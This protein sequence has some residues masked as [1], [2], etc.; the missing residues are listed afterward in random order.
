MIANAEMVDM[1][2]TGLLT[3]YNNSDGPME[4]QQ[5][6]YVR[7]HPRI[8]MAYSVPSV[9]AIHD[10]FGH[11]TGSWTLESSGQST[12]WLRDLLPTYFAKSQI[13]TWGYE[14]GRPK[15]NDVMSEV[16]YIK[17]AMKLLND[18]TVAR[19][20]EPALLIATQDRA[21]LPIFNHTRAMVANQSANSL[22]IFN[23]ITLGYKNK[24]SDL[25]KI[26]TIEG[27]FKEALDTIQQ[28]IREKGYLDC[29]G[30]LSK[31]Y[32][33]DSIPITEGQSSEQITK[34]PDLMSWMRGSRSSTIV[35]CG[36]HGSGKT[37]STRSIYQYLRQSGSSEYVATYFAFDA[38]DR[39]RN[40]ENS[41]LISV[42]Q[43][44][45]FSR[46][47]LFRKIKKRYKYTFENPGLKQDMWILFRALLRSMRPLTLFCIINAVD[48][49]L[50][51]I[52]G[53]LRNL[54]DL[55]EEFTTNLKILFTFTQEAEIPGVIRRNLVINLESFNKEHR[56]LED[57]VSHR[58]SVI[59]SNRPIL[60]E[61]QAEI[62]QKLAG[63]EDFLQIALLTEQLE[64][65]N[66]SSTPDLVRRQIISLDPDLHVLVEKC[67]KD[68]EEWVQLALSW[69]ML[70]ARPL[71][72]R[73]L[74]VAVA[75]CQD[76]RF[77]EANAGSLRAQPQPLITID[78]HVA[79]NIFD[80]L[81][82]VLGPLVVLKGGYIKF[83]NRQV[84]E[85]FASRVFLQLNDWDITR[86]CIMYISTDE[87]ENI[88]KDDGSGLITS[89][90]PERRLAFIDYATNHWPFHYQRTTF[91]AS[92]FRSVFKTL[93][94]MNWMDTWSN[95]LTQRGSP[96]TRQDLRRMN[97]LH[98][99]SELGFPG[100]IKLLLQ[101]QQ[102][103]ADVAIALD[104]ASRREHSEIV[105]QLL[106]YGIQDAE[107]I[108]KALEGPCGQGFAS[109]VD[110]LLGELKSRNFDLSKYP[111][112]LLALAARNGHLS[113]VQSLIDT[114]VS[115]DSTWEG[116]CPLHYA[117]EQGH[118]DIVNVL[119]KNRANPNLVDP[120]KCAPLHLA[121]NNQDLDI[122]Q[123]LIVAKSSVDIEDEDGRR[124]LHISVE[125]GH[126]EAVKLLLTHNVDLEC[127]TNSG[128]TPLHLAAK[129]GHLNI[130][131]LLLKHKVQ[132]DLENEEGC[133]PLLLAAMGGHNKILELLLD[134]GVRLNHLD[135]IGCSALLSSSRHGHNQTA[136][137][138]LENG[139]DPNA[140]DNPDS[141]P[142]IEAV[143]QGETALVRLMIKR[144]AKVDVKPDDDVYFPIHYSVIYS[145]PD[146]VR[147]FI[148]EGCDINS[149]DSDK[150]Q[151]PL[152][153]AMYA[154]HLEIVNILLEAKADVTIKSNTDETVLHFAAYGDHADIASLLLESG[155]DIDAVDYAENT[156]LHHA[157]YRHSENAITFLMRQGANH[158]I[159][160][161][162]FYTPFTYAV[163]LEH[164][165]TVRQLLTLGV[166]PK[167]FDSRGLTSLHIAAQDS[168]IEI[169]KVL[170]KELNVDVN[171]VSSTGETPLH[172]A[173][174]LEGLRWF[175]ENGANANAGSNK[176][177]T[178]L[179]V[180]AQREDKAAV[181][182][183]LEH[184]AQIHAVTKGG[185]TALHY[186]LRVGN[187][188]TITLLL[189][190]GLNPN[191]EA[192]NGVTPL[193]EAINT[194]EAAI[195]KILLDRGAE[196]NHV[197]GYGNTALHYAASMN[198][199]EV[200]TILF[201]RGA[202]IDLKDNDGDTALMTGIYNN[203]LK[204]VEFLLDAGSDKMTVNN[205]GVTLLQM[206]LEKQNDGIVQT[207]VTRK[208]D[209]NAPF[210]FLNTRLLHVAATLDN[211]RIIELLLEAE[212]HMNAPD[213]EGC[214]PLHHAASAGQE[215]NVTLLLEKGSDRNAQDLQG[216]TLIH[217]CVNHFS[218]HNL[219]KLI[220]H[221]LKLRGPSPK[222]LK[223]TDIDGW[224]PLHWACKK[225]EL[226]VVKLL[227]AAKADPLQQ[228]KRGWTPI[229][230]A[231]FHHAQHLLPD[232][233]KAARRTRT[234][235]DRVFNPVTTLKTIV[236][237]MDAEL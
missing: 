81:R 186:A 232:L 129:N 44:I 215:R 71:K 52:K 121:C 92:R 88:S 74:A 28:S 107:S 42:V 219:N 237:A 175:L 59:I 15:E 84:K 73:E 223:E 195:I 153:H 163:Y 170:V 117:V 87:V 112:S 192:A 158:S 89:F 35:L 157:V 143:K 200:A 60:S 115:L 218:L 49:C 55:M 229:M 133:T 162:R 8:T 139:A 51:D 176:D 118:E 194:E 183:L 205:N 7:S 97:S 199:V 22:G 102:Q 172:R 10:I 68:L 145:H 66:F 150:G 96:I 152:L 85:L 98:T 230:I 202:N 99:A 226:G 138:L 46:P 104:L 228:C 21:F 233:Q 95:L 188:E 113:I 208:C 146:I 48:E 50:Q 209:V 147:L 212:A 155:A 83:V 3:L 123:Q 174:F 193:I 179:M 45:L 132:A 164:D 110:I 210:T 111:S 231:T 72:P 171:I 18:I 144:D 206:A 61:V 148:E 100:V 58:T 108:T 191:A 213:L 77:E 56:N 203:H 54:D 69:I 204:M 154:E 105:G 120:N 236:P 79:R 63:C 57:I 23:E 116:S 142:L 78:D 53:Y 38:Q 135:N 181:K 37:V 201:E 106:A 156:A 86:Y 2:A 127:R 24:H 76:P 39:R 214:T 220:S 75:L 109:I 197:D 189:E 19:S 67:L 151:T 43:Q 5:L 217:H 14:S 41:F 177:K 141:L 12:C 20:A 182:L 124:A 131:E 178:P 4:D 130:V 198:L 90:G 47:S 222:E 25:G 9:I 235:E 166:N 64:S 216:R 30:D 101:E 196:V 119:L 114:N 187:L 211:R 221:V 31:I 34:H 70:A 128:N 40:S 136:K 190:A 225:A 103:E 159:E 17:T 1:E 184:G 167:R 160:N 227:I 125:L 13:L 224:T 173:W 91:E 94:N 26:S 16:G 207:L 82:R 234:G 6:E 27:S 185:S 93:R 65:F 33:V 140:N 180:M 62:H 149:I 126:F 168:S 32:L 165:R 80:D 36:K 29:L 134:Q 169:I 122:V 137:L 161:N 11:R